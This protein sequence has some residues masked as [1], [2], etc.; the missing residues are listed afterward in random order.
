MSISTRPVETSNRAIVGRHFRRRADL[1]RRPLK[2]TVPAGTRAVQ[3]D[4]LRRGDA[5]RA[6]SQEIT[7]LRAPIAS[8]INPTQASIRLLRSKR[9]TRDR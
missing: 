4:D 6:R 7:N 2:S 1:A 3:R 5:M 9:A 8:R